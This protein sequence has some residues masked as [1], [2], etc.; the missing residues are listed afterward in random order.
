MVVAFQRRDCLSHQRMDNDVLYRLT[1]SR[2]QVVVGTEK[3]LDVVKNCDYQ[4]EKMPEVLELYHVLSFCP[5]IVPFNSMKHNVFRS[6]NK[7]V[8][9]V[10]DIHFQRKSPFPQR[11]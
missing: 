3:K 9:L 1:V 5:R 8:P 6:P 11:K 10:F 7:L 2:G 4:I